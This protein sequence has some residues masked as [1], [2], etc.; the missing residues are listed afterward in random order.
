[1][2]KSPISEDH[3]LRVG[4][5]EK[6]VD[7]LLKRRREFCSPCGHVDSMKLLRFYYVLGALFSYEGTPTCI[8]HDLVIKQSTVSTADKHK[9]LRPGSGCNKQGKREV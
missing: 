1:M 8:Q 2:K 7:G 3:F 5:Q 9:P 6:E 4:I